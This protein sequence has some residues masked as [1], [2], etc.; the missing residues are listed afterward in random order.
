MNNQN[1]ISLFE[2]QVAKVPT[3]LAISHKQNSLNYEAFNAKV[4]QLAHYLISKGI[5]QDKPVALCMQRSIDL[6]I[7]MFAILKAGAGYLPIDPSHPK[8]RLA[9]ILQS[10]QVSFVL[11]QSDASHNLVGFHGQIIFVDQCVNELATQK[12]SNPNVVIDPHH[13]AYVI[14][15]SGSTGTPKGVQ[16]E[17]YNAVNYC[18]W[19]KQYT[20]CQAGQTIDFSSNHIFDM[21]ITITLVPLM[22]GMSVFICEDSIKKNIQ[23][24]VHFLNQNRIDLIKLTPSF[25]KVLT[26]TIKNMQLA[27]P[28]LKSLIIGGENLSTADC[29]AWLDLIP[30]TKLFNEYGPT[31]T[32]V[33]ATQFCV[34]T[35]NIAELGLNVPIGTPGTNMQCMILN[36]ERQPVHP[37]ECGEL[38]IAGDGVARGYI[39]DPQMTEQKFLLQESGQRLYKTGDLCQLNPAG[40]ID[41][42]GRID[43]QVKIRGFR[44]DPCEIEKLLTQHPSLSA[45]AVVAQPD[46]LN[47]MR[48]VAYY[49]VQAGKGN[50]GFNQLREYLQQFI[51]DYI[52]PTAFVPLE[53]FPLNANGKLDRSALSIP[54]FT[55]IKAFRAPKSL[56]EKKLAQLWSTEL[57]IEQISIDDD[58]F[59]LGGHS[60]AAARIITQINH[61]LKKNIT[62]QDLYQHPSIFQLAAIIKTQKSAQNAAI[63]FTKNTDLDL[64]SLSDFQLTLWLSHTF[65]P[66]ARKL[67]VVARKRVK[68]KVD[69]ARL[70]AA[71]QALVK[72]Q[73]VL[74]YQIMKAKPAQRQTSDSDFSLDEQDIRECNKRTTEQVLEN[75]LDELRTLYPWPAKS[76]SIMGRLYYLADDTVELQIAMPHIICDEDSIHI[77]F[78]DLSRF[79][80]KETTCPD[81]LS[82]DAD[83]QKY[84][85]HEQAYF[86]HYLERDITFWDS[87]LNH[88]SLLSVPEQHVVKKMDKTDI[89][90]STYQHIS[91]QKLL[92]LKDYCA[93]RQLSMHDCLCAA[94]LLAFRDCCAKDLS[95]SPYLYVNLVKSTRDD[96]AYDGT[97]GC[98]LRLE[99]IKVA[100][101]A[102]SDLVSLAEL[103]RQEKMKT[104]NYQRCPSLIKL[105]STQTLKQAGNP[106]RR[107]LMNGL[108]S[109][110][111]AC[112]G[113][114]KT[115]RRI[116]QLCFSRL[117]TFNTRDNFLVNLNIQN[118]FNAEQ[119]QSPTFLGLDALPI[120]SQHFDLLNIDSV[121]DVCV[122]ADDKNQSSYVVI[123]ANLKPAFRQKIATQMIG[124][125]GSVMTDAQ[126]THSA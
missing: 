85:V 22:L 77:L 123:S 97:I 104:S 118:S 80:L 37:G 26:D 89:P 53:S 119:Q 102:Q 51:P 7:A 40:L 81:A 84:I 71:F 66:K 78:A 65:A 82:D 3:Q 29:K 92:Q 8:E 106:V 126:V 96:P 49:I 30:H 57:G 15:T 110:Y 48:L 42:L 23:Q 5:E 79:Y 27:L 41:Y 2:E 108:L 101:N 39:N 11:T 87:Y 93:A 10:S 75:S 68:G 64:F 46:S 105:A 9:L 38:Y 1:I 107:F 13:L 12:T 95:A 28:H 59:E 94:L 86:E 117:A 67:N 69:K 111:A 73:N 44:V 83:Y 17:H 35:G 100:I 6:L 45:S 88:A 24:Y 90:Y 114:S 70:L 20:N 47:E 63:Q 112:S 43:H 121:L 125:I 99:P 55:R 74:T 62:F 36:E 58:F 116:F 52:I 109:V 16:I 91:N 56:I 21:A 32:T 50:L 25:L 14:Y 72:K 115:Y 18:A 120:K 60:L 34:H 113:L 124:H 76:P 33:G 61:Q 19:F 54:E 4:N 103:I 98:F 122:V 31:E